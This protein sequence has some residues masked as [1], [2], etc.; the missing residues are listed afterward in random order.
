MTDFHDT[1]HVHRYQCEPP[2]GPTSWG[3]CA[4]GS[5][6]E[7][8]NSLLVDLGGA[9]SAISAVKCRECGATLINRGALARHLAEEHG[10]MA[11]AS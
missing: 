6:R 5:R 8:R 4:C 2:N 11:V 1:R 9:E 10:R 3:E 7:F